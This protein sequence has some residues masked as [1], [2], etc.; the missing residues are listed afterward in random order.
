MTA[1]RMGVVMDVEAIVHKNVKAIVFLPVRGV[2]AHVL[3]D[4]L[5]VV[6]PV[7]L[8]AQIIV[9]E[10]VLILAQLLVYMIALMFVFIKTLNIKQKQGW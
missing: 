10:V 5:V 2:I 4:A 6:E 8:V 7:V 1:V 9:L 3:V